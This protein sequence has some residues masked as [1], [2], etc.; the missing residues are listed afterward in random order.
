LVPLL[1]LED[2]RMSLLALLALQLLIAGAMMK[3][4]IIAGVV[5][6]SVLAGSAIA[7][8]MPMKAASVRAACAQFGG[9]YVGGQ[10]G[11]STY[12][13]TFSDLDAFAKGID[14]KLPNSVSDSGRGWLAGAQAGFNWQSGCTVFGIETD[15]ARTKATA[16]SFNSDGDSPDSDTLT[17]ESKLRWFGTT[18]VRTGVVVD[19]LLLYVTSGVAYASVKRDLEFFSD[20]PIHRPVTEA[21]S[22]SRTR[23]GWTAGAGTE[24]AINANWSL[25][26]E[27]LYMQFAKD[28]GTFV[29]TV[30]APGTTTRFK[31]DDSAWVGRIGLN[32]RFGAPY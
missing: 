4:S 15:W 25:K 13:H 30:I 29:T 9:V 18:R 3:R 24:W 8:D 27:F 14:D 26:S 20:G 17:V 6:S 12:N 22:S 16:S 23:F 32:Y 1:H 7:A 2:V 11:V 31:H 5:L 21:F 28:E 19:N 10:A